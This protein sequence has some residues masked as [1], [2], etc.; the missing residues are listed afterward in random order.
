MTAVRS[1]CSGAINTKNK[2][3]I[4]IV[5]Y[6]RMQHDNTHEQSNEVQ[7]LVQGT[8]ENI[9]GLTVRKVDK[10]LLNI[11][12]TPVFAYDGLN[13]FYEIHLN[14]TARVLSRSS[15]S[16]HTSELNPCEAYL[17]ISITPFINTTENKNLT[18]TTIYWDNIPTDAPP[19]NTPLNYTIIIEESGSVRMNLSIN[20]CDC[21]AIP[22]NKLT[23]KNDTYSFSV[24]VPIVPNSTCSSTASVALSLY[25][26]LE[27]DIVLHNIIG[28]TKQNKRI[29]IG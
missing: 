17:N 7:L 5:C 20:I 25:M 23:L 14:D 24:T 13:L 8:I 3:N 26:N 22:S 28:S 21:P 15:T 6:G 11:S 27:V 16:W 19:I 2:K 4:S 9:T 18:G 1:N 12:W 29:L 10:N